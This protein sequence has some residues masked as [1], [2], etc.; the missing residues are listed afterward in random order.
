MSLLREEESFW[1]RCWV[2]NLVHYFYQAIIANGEMYDLVCVKWDCTR[3]LG[4]ALNH[5]LD[6]DV[7]EMLISRIMFN[8]LRLINRKHLFQK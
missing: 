2:S 5:S 1:D 6:W 8:Q 3:Y 7:Q 4:Y